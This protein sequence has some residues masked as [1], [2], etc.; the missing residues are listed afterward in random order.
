[1]P[2]LNPLAGCESK[3]SAGFVGLLLLAIFWIV[4]VTTFGNYTKNDWKAFSIGYSVT[5]GVLLL[6]A[7][8]AYLYHKS[9]N[10]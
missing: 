3:F 4:L 7:G 10:K 6:M 5:I 9:K 2:L 1:M 8:G